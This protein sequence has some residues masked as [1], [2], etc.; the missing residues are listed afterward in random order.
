MRWEATS[1]R[2]P[3]PRARRS[4]WRERARALPA[5]AGRRRDRDPRR[6]RARAG[7]LAADRGRARRREGRDGREGRRRGAQERDF[8]RRADAAPQGRQAGRHLQRRQHRRGGRE[9]RCSGLGRLE[10]VS[11]PALAAFFP[12]AGEGTVVLDVGANAECKPQYLVQFAHMGSCYARY[13][14]GRENPRVGLL[15]IGEE[16]SKGNQLVQETLPLLRRARAPEL[17][18]QRR[19][20]RPVQGHLRRDR[21]RRLHRQRAAQDRGERRDVPGATRCATRSSAIRWRCSG[22]CS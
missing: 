12:N 20:P 9:P 10:G 18:R 4:R 19:G 1:A 22:R 2:Y 8:A 5:H 17:H 21:D 14:L 15:S 11:R 3:W 13:L 16:D 7:G 6:A